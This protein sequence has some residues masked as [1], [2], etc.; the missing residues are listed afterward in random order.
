MNAKALLALLCASAAM[1]TPLESANNGLLGR[2]PLPQGNCCSYIPGTC[3]CGCC[4]GG[5][6]ATNS[7]PNA[8]CP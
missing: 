8:T 6:C 7:D 5:P 4:P 1:A 2:E 3:N